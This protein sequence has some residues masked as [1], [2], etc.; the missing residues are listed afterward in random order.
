[1]YSCFAIVVVR[2]NSVII[3]GVALAVI[4]KQGGEQMADLDS[5]AHRAAG[6]GLPDNTLFDG[7]RG[8]KSRD[9]I[10]GGFCVDHKLCVGKH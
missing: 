8:G 1:M 5:C 3:S 6:V 4:G 10:K 9:G 7:N 2:D